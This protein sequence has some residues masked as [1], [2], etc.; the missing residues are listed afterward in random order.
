MTRL[1]KKSKTMEQFIKLRIL[2]VIESIARG[3]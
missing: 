2:K 1:T 3:S